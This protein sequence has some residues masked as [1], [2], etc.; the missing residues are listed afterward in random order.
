[1]VHALYLNKAVLKEDGL[2]CQHAKSLKLV[3]DTLQL[4]VAV[5]LKDSDE[6]VILP[7]GRTLSRTPSHQFRGEREVVE[8]KDMHRFFISGKQFG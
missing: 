8:I 2:A 3:T 5:V 6:G 7:I 1:M 4:Q